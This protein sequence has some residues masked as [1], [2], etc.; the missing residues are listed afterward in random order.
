M[1]VPLLVPSNIP[2]LFDA[3]LET[4]DKDDLQSGVGYKNDL[5]LNEIIALTPM[6]WAPLVERGFYYIGTDGLYFH[7]DSA[8]RIAPGDVTEVK[9]PKLPAP[10]YPISVTTYYRDTTGSITVGYKWHQKVRFSGIINHDDP[11]KVFERVDTT[12]EGSIVNFNFKYA[13]VN[14]HEF[15][16]SYNRNYM[17]YIK[18]PDNLASTGAGVK[19]ITLN[20]P[21]ISTMPFVFSKAGQF[22]NRTSSP[23]ASGDWNISSDGTTLSVYV[24]SDP[25]DIGYITYYYNYPASILFSKSCIINHGTSAV[26]PNPQLMST[27]EIMGVSNGNT[28]LCFGMRYFPVLKGSVN[29]Y[30]EDGGTVTP[31][32]VMEN[33]DGSG[34]TDR[35]C[36]VDADLGLVIFGNNINGMIPPTN[37]TIG[38]V[39]TSVPIIEYETRATG[40]IL[41]NELNMHPLFNHT[42][43]GFLYLE[44][45]LD[46]LG[47]LFL[48]TNKNELLYGNDYAVLTCIARNPMGSPISNILIE[49][50]PPTDGYLNLAQTGVSVNQFTKADGTAQVIYHPPSNV[51]DMA[52]EV[53]LYLPDGSYSSPYLTTSVTNDTL[54]TTFPADQATYTPDMNEVLTFIVVD[55]DPLA[56]YYNN[57]RTGGLMVLL[58]EFDLETNNFAPVRPVSVTQN[59]IVYGKSLPTPSDYGAIRKFIIVIQ[60]PEFFICRAI[61]PLTGRTIYSN[62][63]LTLLTAPPY[64]VG[65]FTLSTLQS[66]AGSAIGAATYFTIDKKGQLNA[67]FSVGGD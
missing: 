47:S 27:V 12:T 39:Y 62:Q 14:K 61:D 1:S 67:A 49:F 58:Y 31:W 37:S 65:E 2:C 29:V 7:S 50:M 56:P 20:P 15:V 17:K 59:R 41:G 46:I 10:G 57:S 33:L 19:N 25:T 51:L 55:S 16:I 23:S 48:S 63:L 36:M 42:P 38:V 66:V 5:N 4:L 26:P 11:N 40:T 35:D 43:R 18:L 44:Q 24:S 13:D 45:R 32:S 34:P 28:D 54:I 9:L 22:K 3:S 52:E 8:V 60:R 53:N 6:H 21:A 64:Q 30:V